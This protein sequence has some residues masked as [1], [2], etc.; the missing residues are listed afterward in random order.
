VAIIYSL[1]KNLLPETASWEFNEGLEE[2]LL[3]SQVGISCW[4]SQGEPMGLKLCIPQN[5][6][7]EHLQP[8]NPHCTNESTASPGRAAV[9]T[10]ASSPRAPETVTKDVLPL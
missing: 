7:S 6:A 2:R 10:G 9:D 5:V 3:V 1:C 8:S 4:K